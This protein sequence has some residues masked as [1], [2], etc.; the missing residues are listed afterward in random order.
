MLFYSVTDHLAYFTSYC[1][2]ARKHGIK[3]L[4]LCQMP[5]HLHDSVIVHD[6]KQL[7]AFKRDQNSWFAKE[8]NEYCGI[9]GP[10][11][12]H[13]FG[14]SMKTDE[15]K[16]RSNLIYVGNNPVERHLVGKAE[17]YRWNYIAYANSDNPFSRKLSIKKCSPALKAAVKEVQYQHSM[18]M[19]LTHQMLNRLFAKLEDVE[20]QQLIDYS[21]SHY[22]VIDYE[23]ALDYFGGSYKRFIMALHSTTGSEHDIRE[24]FTG[25]SD[26][27]YAQMSNLLLGKYDLNDIHQFLRMDK[28]ELYNYLLGKTAASARQVVKYLRMRDWELADIQPFKQWSRDPGV[29]GPWGKRLGMSDLLV[30]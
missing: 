18:D 25:R 21:I 22:N 12:R 14:S 29:L 3:V 30:P 28:K 27:Y 5:D 11:F 1:V 24:K 20:I 4:G 8:Q 6:K 7:G 15:K 16:I 9:E 13:P 19:P 23:A 10:L 2:L 26:V 17:D